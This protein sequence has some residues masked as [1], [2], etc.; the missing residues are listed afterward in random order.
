LLGKIF[1]VRVTSYILKVSYSN[2]ILK[3][4]I[5]N[6]RRMASSIRPEH[7]HA[8]CRCRHARGSLWSHAYFINRIAC[9]CGS[10]IHNTLLELA[11]VKLNCKYLISSIW[12]KPMQE[13]VEKYIKLGPVSF[14]IL[15]CLL[16]IL[17]AC[18]F[19]S[20]EFQ[21]NQNCIRWF[22]ICFVMWF[23]TLLISLPWTLLLLAGTGF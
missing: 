16:I 10:F 6:Y 4:E 1:K 14:Y 17:T 21:H 20:N 11:N 2:E 15:Y 23:Y 7:S 5:L 22:F 8:T 3:C 13:L 19:I 18:S 12:P 9:S